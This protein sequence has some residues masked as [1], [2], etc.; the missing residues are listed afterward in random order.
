MAHVT[1]RERGQLTIPASL[2]KELKLEEQATMTIVKVGHVLLLTPRT[3][4]GE[5]VARKAAQL[6]KRKGLRLADV[7]TDLKKQRE[8]YNRERDGG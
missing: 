5:T 3:L 4:V 6:M 2:R 8:R 1:I 7:L